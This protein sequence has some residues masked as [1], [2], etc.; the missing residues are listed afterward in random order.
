M[1]SRLLLLGGDKPSTW[2]VYNDLVARFGLFPAIIE[3]PVPRLALVQN[4]IRKLGLFEVAGQIGFA[5]LIRPVLNWTAMSRLKRLLRYHGLESIPPQNDAIHHVTSVNGTACHS[6]LEKH[7]PDIVVIS[8]TRILSTSTLSKLRGPVINI[9]HGITP[10]YRGAHGAYWALMRND[11]SQC[12]VTVHLVDEGIDTGNII[13]QA[14][15]SPDSHDSFVTYPVLQTAAA[16]DLIADAIA[17][18]EAKKL[19]TRP[20]SGPSAVWYHPGF[21][22]YLGGALRGV[23]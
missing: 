11:H 19:K 17:A 16:L 15:L 9:H 23:R 20:V 1:A 4:R 3:K 8:G 21:F 10:Q 7:D 5:L 22:E 12:G 2:I 18:A 13:S 6:L 14:R